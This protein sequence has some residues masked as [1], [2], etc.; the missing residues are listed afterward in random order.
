MKKVRN[1][2]I[3]N[4]RYLCLIVVIAFG[5]IGIVGSGGGGGG[6]AGTAPTIDNVVLTDGNFNPKSE[7]NIGDTYN[8]LVTATD[9]DKNMEELIIEQYHPSDSTGNPYYGPDVLTLTSQAYDSMTYYL[10]GGGTINGPSGTW[11]IEFQI[12]DSTGLESNVFTVFALVN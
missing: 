8:V 12:E 7:F 6:S 9:P 5:L 1:E 11:R 4:L 3:N 10:I 2:L